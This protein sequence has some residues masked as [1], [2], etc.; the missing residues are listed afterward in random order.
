MRIIILAVLIC[1][2]QAAQV[3]DCGFHPLIANGDVTE[4]PSGKELKVQCAIYYKLEGPEKVG[5][6]EG[7]WTELPVCKLTGGGGGGEFLRPDQIGVLL[8]VHFC[9]SHP[10][11]ANGDVTEMP[12][13]KELKV[14]CVRYYKLDGPKTVGCVNEEWTPLPE[15]K[16][17]CK[18]EGERIHSSQSDEYLQEG[19]E[20]R[21]SCAFLKKINVKCFNGTT[22]YGECKCIL[23]FI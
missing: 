23:C 14:Q 15:C 7:E 16:P 1:A 21:Y 3:R 2:C 20:K 13:G 5:C 9:G 11:I 10:L 22:I 6:V 4:L 19:E 18:V 8:P 17:P 12:S